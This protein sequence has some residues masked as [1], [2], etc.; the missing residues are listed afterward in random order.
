MTRLHVA[1]ISWI[2]AF[3]ISAGWTMYRD[4]TKPDRHPV[5]QQASRPAPTPS[6]QDVIA[7]NVQ[8]DA[9]RMA[10]AFNKTNDLTR[11][12]EDSKSEAAVIYRRLLIEGRCANF[13]HQMTFTP[14]AMPFDGTTFVPALATP[15]NVVEAEVKLVNGEGH[16]FLVT[17]WRME[18][19]AA[20]KDAAKAG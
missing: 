9:E 2:L 19:N 10:A 20:G 5:Q 6:L 7:C 18:A 4:E 8:A 15:Y 14:I 12:L 11:A 1:L 3:A 16:F 17:E 13:E